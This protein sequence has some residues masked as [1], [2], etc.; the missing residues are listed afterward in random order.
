MVSPAFSISRSS[1]LKSVFLIALCANIILWFVSIEKAVIAPATQR[2]MTGWDDRQSLPRKNALV[3]LVDIAA[4]RK[5]LSDT[6]LHIDADNPAVQFVFVAGLEGTGHHLFGRTLLK[7][8]PLQQRLSK[9]DLNGTVDELDLSLHKKI[10]KAHCGLPVRVSSA[11]KKVPIGAGINET[12]SNFRLI[13]DHFEQE[14]KEAIQNNAPYEMA[15]VF[16]GVQKV[17]ASYPFGYDQ[18]RPLRYPK[19]DMYDRLCQKAGVSCRIALIHRDPYAVVRSNQSRKFDKRP[20]QAIHLYDSMN[21]ILLRHLMRFSDRTIGCWDLLGGDTA[22]LVGKLMGFNHT[23]EWDAYRD[24][25]IE[26]RSTPM[27][28]Q[29]QLDLVKKKYELYMNSFL[30]SHMDVVNV[31]HHN[32]QAS[33]R[34]GL[35]PQ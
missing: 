24:S 6:A 8:S 15:T 34:S 33:G 27:T 26:H 16:L 18:C 3:S 30:Q 22:P 31:C 7:G 2:R 25:A 12:L 10:W 4:T 13:R 29:D 32:V 1:G 20:V 5:S 9:L 21:A 14:R 23:S 28:K 35:G 19:L 11:N 17:K